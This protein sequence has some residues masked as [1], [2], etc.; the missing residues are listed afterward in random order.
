MNIG[1]IYITTIDN[2][3]ENYSKVLS[4]INE[5]GLPNRCNYQFLGM[6]GYGLTPSDIRDAGITLYPYWN[7]SKPNNFEFDSKNKFWHRDMTKGE[8]GCVMS[9]IMA[10]EDAYE[11]GYDNVLVFEDDI[12]SDG[13]SFDW[14]VLSDLKSLEYD[15]FYLGRLI[16]GGF[17]GVVDTPIP[18]Y[19][20]L[21]VPG[22]SYQAHAYLLS[23]EGIRKIVEDYLP[24]LKKNLVPTDEFLPALINY[25]PRED[26]NNLF[27]GLIRGYG[28]TDHT[29][30]G[31][32]QERT[33]DYGNSMT[34]PNE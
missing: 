13:S 20:H 6:N 25:S 10:W 31:V 30:K 26:M 9:H 2:T 1:H 14:N 22:Y 23:K 8:I 19:P 12:I 17:Q 33:E 28:L 32:L 24:I 3:E 21:C 29:G 7:L 4:N 34:M 5:I 11:N 27:N 18:N 16:Q 15:L